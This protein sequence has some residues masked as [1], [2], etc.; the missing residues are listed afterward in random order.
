MPVGITGPS[1][2]HSSGWVAGNGLM[3]VIQL[4]GLLLV[5]ALPRPWAQGLP[6]WLPLFPVWVGTGLLFQVAV[7]AVL[8]GVFSP[9]RRPPTGAWAASSRGCS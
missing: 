4:A 9:R 7:G 8:V 1:L 3:A 6:A 5:L 2:L